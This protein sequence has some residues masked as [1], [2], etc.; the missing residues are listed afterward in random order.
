M[1]DEMDIYSIAVIYTKSAIFGGYK[2]EHCL[3]TADSE[4]EAWGSVFKKLP[5]NFT[6]VQKDM[7]KIKKET[8]LNHIQDEP[9]STK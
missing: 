7:L 8:Y 3:L 5:E 9:I 1:E 6:I 2:M 4:D